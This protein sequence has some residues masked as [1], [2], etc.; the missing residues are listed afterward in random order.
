M[1]IQTRFKVS[2]RTYESRAELCRLPMEII[3][4]SAQEGG[5]MRLKV[6]NTKTG[7][8]FE[9]ENTNHAWGYLAVDFNADLVRGDT[10]RLLTDGTTWYLLD[11]CC[12]WDYLPAYYTVEVVK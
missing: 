3:R 6:T 1:W 5:E 8:V 11:E 4:K 9:R 10:E 2:T 12:N 7:K